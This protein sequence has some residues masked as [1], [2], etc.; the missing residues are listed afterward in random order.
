MIVCGEITALLA[1]GRGCRS[2]A[3]INLFILCESQH[4]LARAY[5]GVMCEEASHKGS[6]QLEGEK[7][8]TC[9]EVAALWTIG[10]GCGR[11]AF[12]KRAQLSHRLCVNPYVVLFI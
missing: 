1:I 11:G 7:I 2:G 8:I 10:G 9:D 3:F 6:A 12:G 5:V 4:M